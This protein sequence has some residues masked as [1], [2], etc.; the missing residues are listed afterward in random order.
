MA[1]AGHPDG[2]QLHANA[3]QLLIIWNIDFDNY[4]ADP[5]AGYAIIRPMAAAPPCETI[6]ELKR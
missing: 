3:G 2:F 5:Q 1:G 6:A 4:G